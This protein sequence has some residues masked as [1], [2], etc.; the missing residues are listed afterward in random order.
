[1]ITRLMRCEGCS[2]PG[3]LARSGTGLPTGPIHP[4]RQVKSTSHFGVLC[5]NRSVQTVTVPGIVRIGKS[6]EPVMLQVR[7]DRGAMHMNSGEVGGSV[8]IVSNVTMRRIVKAWEEST[9]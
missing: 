2:F 9:V 6:D 4:A 1:M 8:L 3:R 7:F 5:F